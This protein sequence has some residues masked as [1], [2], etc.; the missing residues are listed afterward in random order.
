MAHDT[1]H[2][3]IEHSNSTA[4]LDRSLLDGMERSPAA[5]PSFLISGLQQ[6]NSTFIPGIYHPNTAV[7]ALPFS[8]SLITGKPLD[9]HGLGHACR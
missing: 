8:Q 1:E 4:L 6:V 5:L 9:D 7:A 3:K 2:Q